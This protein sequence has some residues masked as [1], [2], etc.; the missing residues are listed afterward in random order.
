MP[1]TLKVLTS[2]GDG[3]SRAVVAFGCHPSVV[4]VN[5]GPPLVYVSYDDGGSWDAVPD[6]VFADA[7]RCGLL[8]TSAD[9]RTATF[10][11]AHTGSFVGHVSNAIAYREHAPPGELEVRL[12]YSWLEPNSS[13]HADHPRLAIQYGTL[14]FPAKRGALG[15]ARYRGGHVLRPS[16]EDDSF[17]RATFTQPWLDQ[18]AASG[19]S[20]TAILWWIEGRP[21]D[22]THASSFR[23]VAGEADF[24]PIQPLS[25]TRGGAHRW[26]PNLSCRGIDGAE[27]RGAGVNAQGRVVDANGALLPGYWWCFAG[28]YDRGT[29]WVD[30]G[31]RTHFFHTWAESHAGAPGPNSFLHYN[32]AMIP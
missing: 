29:S 8:A 17:F 20:D 4:G 5:D 19:V 25:A 32:H 14:S 15:N 18:P 24:G 9:E 16:H 26:K 7:P 31:G 30:A 22:G 2:V 3:V 11:P 12:A 27:R 13:G 28:D 1:T 6:A 23:T 10:F 21:S